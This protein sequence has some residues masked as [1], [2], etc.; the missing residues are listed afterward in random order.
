VHFSSLDYLYRLSWPQTLV[1][2]YDHVISRMKGPLNS[3]IAV[4]IAGDLDIHWLH[5]VAGYH[6]D[7]SVSPR[8]NNGILWH[9]KSV[10]L[11]PE[12][13]G[14]PDLHAALDLEAW[15]GKG[16]S[17]REGTGIRISLRQDCGDLPNNGLIRKAFHFYPHGASGRQLHHI[18]FWDI[19]GDLYVPQINKGDH[20]SRP[21]DGQPL[22]H[23]G[24]LSPTWVCSLAT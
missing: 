7:Q 24:V 3:N 20:L 16:H 5:D 21:A 11:C 18:A 8:C 17:H 15:V 4:V 13:K 14:R 10:F 1:P 9:Q 23:L 2:S 22:S 6:K 19:H 12:V